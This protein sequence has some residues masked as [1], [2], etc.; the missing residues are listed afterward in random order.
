MTIKIESITISSGTTTDAINLNSRVLVG[1]HIPASVAS[2][3]MKIQGISNA[4]DTHL[5]VQDGLAQFGS[6]GDLTFTIAASRYI[7]IAPSITAGLT[8]I[9]LVFGSSETT[10]TYKI[11]L[12]D[13]E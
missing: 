1:V 12:R 2:T 7:P 9:K 11:V 3:T 4:G 8:N 10:K 6:A 13:I 5:T